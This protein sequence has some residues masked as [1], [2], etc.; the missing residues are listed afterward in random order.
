MDRIPVFFEGQDDLI[1]PLAVSIESICYNTQS[2]VDFYILD[3]GVNCLNKKLLRK[4]IEK[5]ENTTIEFIPIDLKQFKGLKGYTAGNFI[6]C[7]SRLLIP[8]LKPE[9]DKVIYLDNDTMTLSDIR[10]LWEQDLNGY[11]IAACPDIGYNLCHQ[12][13]CMKFGIPQD[14]IFLNAGVL[15]IDCAAWRKNNVGQ[16]LLELA[17]KIKDHLLLIQEDLLNLYYKNN[18]YKRLDLRFNM[19]QNENEIQFVC[20]PDITNEYIETERKNT[21]IQ[22][23]TPKKPWLHQNILN[24]EDFWFFAMRTPF[25]KGLEI[26]LQN[27]MFIPPF[28]KKKYSLFGFLPLLTVKKKNK[29]TRYKLFGFLPIM[30]KKEG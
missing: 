28:N 2:Q 17:V 24:E 1:G 6:D 8:E 7:Y 14:Q 22:H 26:K 4:I 30:K 13:R 29:T 11:E 15:I 25:G 18:N 16:K 10:L 19:R 21:V 27:S 5:Y 12:T 23:F 3:C 20:A 9:F